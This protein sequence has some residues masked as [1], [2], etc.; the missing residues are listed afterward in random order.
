MNPQLDARRL[1]EEQIENELGLLRTWQLSLNEALRRQRESLFRFT[2][3]K[4]YLLTFSLIFLAIL[5]YIVFALF[6]SEKQDLIRLAEKNFTTTFQTMNS[7]GAEALSSGEQDR[8]VLRA[9][10]REVFNSKL[11]GLQEVFFVDADRRFYAYQ[12]IRGEDLGDSATASDSLWNSLEAQADQRI[13]SD[14]KIY[15]TKKLFYEASG[16]NIFVGYSRLLFTVDHIN[17]LI[18]AKQRQALIVGLSGFATSLVILSIVTSL[19][20]RRIQV[21]NDG[22]KQVIQGIFEPLPVKGNDELSE[23][24]DSFNKMMLAV[25]ER[26]MMS[27]YVSQLT[28]GMIRRASVD[29][30]AALDGIKEEICV[31]FS[32]VRGFTAFAEVNEPQHVVAQ[33][34][35]LLNLQV[36]I[37]KRY[38][39]DIDKFVGDEVMAVFRGSAK[40]QRAVAA[41]IA[42]QEKLQPI[43]K[44]EEAYS[45]LRIGIG[46]NTGWAVTGNIGSQDRMDFTAIGDVVNTAA[47]LCSVAKADE[48]LI[49]EEVAHHLP[50]G[51]VTLSEPFTLL[52]KNKLY[53][54]T[55][56]Q[57]LYD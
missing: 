16:Q 30:P 41:A 24:T 25:K 53:A 5:S 13:I 47:R 55:I 50:K 28:L 36:E 23:L 3:Q 11:D 45:R 21:L 9:F 12:N 20:V 33:L 34:N 1:E 29:D 32:D 38:G 54:V 15:L 31:L 46:I 56:Y 18:E 51:S 42:I 35:R 39:G 19:F 17:Q 22:T 49:S 57:V 40:E 48:I 7:I 6:D 52:L 10:I 37:I 44:A 27:K 2:L 8:L 4:K 43:F 26:L 14:N